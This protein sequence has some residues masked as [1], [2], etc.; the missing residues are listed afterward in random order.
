MA[1]VIACNTSKNA[2]SGNDPEKLN[3][4][5][6]VDY[7]SAPGENW[8]SLYLTKKP[9]M[10]F[11]VADNRVTGTTS[12]NSFSGPIKIEGNKISFPEPFAMTRMLCP[13][14]GESV[15]LETL[16]KVNTYSTDGKTLNFIMGDVA[17]LRLVKRER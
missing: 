1:L 11:S 7:L 16:K 17:I 9:E 6:T 4:S 10:N 8:D 14:K 5:W 3:G 12:C 15:F 13:G 2:M